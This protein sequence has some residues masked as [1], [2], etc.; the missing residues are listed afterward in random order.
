MTNNKAVFTKDTANKKMTIVRTFAAPLQQVWDAW[1]QSDK[2]DQ[3]WAPEPYKAVTKKMDFSEGGYWLYSMNGPEGD[4]HFAK[5]SYET[6][7]PANYYTGLSMFTDENGN[8][9]SDMPNRPWK[10]QFS[11]DGA[12]TM[13]TVEINFDNEQQM[14]TLLE[15]GFQ[16]GFTMGLNNLENLLQK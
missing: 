4:K 6:I 10:V 14:N 7:D 3:W 15:M 12:A 8:P 9:N 2:L 5:F 16:E 11:G 1:T 13:V